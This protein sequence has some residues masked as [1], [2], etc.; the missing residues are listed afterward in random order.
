MFKKLTEHY[1]HVIEE[2]IEF[3]KQLYIVNKMSF[4]KFST[5]SN[6]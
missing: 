4:I 6:R 1:F 2:I 5:R 3:W